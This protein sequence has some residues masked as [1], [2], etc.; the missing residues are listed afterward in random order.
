MPTKTT[1]EEFFGSMMQDF[2]DKWGRPPDDQEE[3]ILRQAAAGME[4]IWA[5]ATF[6]LHRS[7]DLMQEQHRDA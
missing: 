4:D 3:D 7:I 5:R 1:K 2:H 6:N